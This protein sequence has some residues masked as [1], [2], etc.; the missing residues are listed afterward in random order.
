MNRINLAIFDLDE[1]L[2]KSSIDYTKI[3][4]Q[5]YDLFPTGQ[6]H[7]SFWNLSIL[8]L[9]KELEKKDKEAYFDGLAL[10]E[11]TENQSV[12]NAC[13]MNGAEK[14][15]EILQK[16]EILGYI[17]TNNSQDTVYLH[18]KRPEFSFLKK[19]TIIT[20]DDL[21]NPKPE[22]D[23]ILRIM[24]KENIPKENS[25]FIGDSYLDANAA[26]KAGIRF[27]LFNSRNLDL[28]LLPEKPF[29]IIDQWSEFETLIERSED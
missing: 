10:V 22:P 1:T 7:S 4:Q 3:K 24:E 12:K 26:S 23:G 5:L 16:H 13:I 27:F 21:I 28:S 19:F 25:I 6:T 11:D 14:V 18:L 29:A 20:R 15:P 9:L 2:I 17:Y 8:Q